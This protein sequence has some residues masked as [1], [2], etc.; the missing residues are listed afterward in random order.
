VG[1]IALIGTSLWPAY[2]QSASAGD[3]RWLAEAF[4]RA[5]AASILLAGWSGALLLVLGDFVLRIW[6]HGRL[7]WSPKLALLLAIWIVGQSFVVGA[8][9]FLAG[10]SRMK[11]M[12]TI[13]VA[14]GAAASIGSIV[15]VRWFGATGVA[16]SMAISVFGSAFVLI[17]AAR[18]VVPRMS[19]RVL[20]RSAVVAVGTLIAVS[21]L[22][23]SGHSAG[24]NGGAASLAGGCLLTALY[25]SLTWYG[26]ATSDHRRRVRTLMNNAARFLAKRAALEGFAG[27]R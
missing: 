6:L 5:S 18:S 3:H 16:V 7:A 20:A 21:A 23:A 24:M 19:S 2:A 12:A 13:T 1:F 11:S 15:L 27:P 26:V 4:T 14:E 22:L 8:W 25:G 9:T 10:V 17:Q